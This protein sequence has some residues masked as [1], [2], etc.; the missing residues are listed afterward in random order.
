MK[1]DLSYRIRS[2]NATVQEDWIT[3]GTRLSP[4][5]T[6]GRE[7]WITTGIRLSPCDPHGQEDRITTCIRLSL[8]DATGSV[9]CGSLC[10]DK[11]RLDDGH[12]TGPGLTVGLSGQ[13][14]YIPHHGCYSGRSDLRQ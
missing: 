1:D 13:P 11:S 14:G 12:H 7:D 2:Y 5:D 10:N 3:T 8:D 4:C 6:V 9:C